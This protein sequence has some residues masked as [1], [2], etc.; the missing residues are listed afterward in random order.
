MT[1]LLRAMMTAGALGALIAIGTGCAQE[2]R[3]EDWT[4]EPVRFADAD[5]GFGI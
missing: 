2:P 3:P 1:G 5:V 4:L